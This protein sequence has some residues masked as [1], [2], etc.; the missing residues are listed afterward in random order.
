MKINEIRKNE[1]ILFDL[2]HKRNELLGEMTTFSDEEMAKLKRIEFAIDS[3]A[4]I[5]KSITL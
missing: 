1:R 3:E 4:N 2:I 5:Y